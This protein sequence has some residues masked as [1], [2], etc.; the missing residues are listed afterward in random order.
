MKKLGFGLMRLPLLDADD[1]KSIDLETVK[2]MV[3]RFLERGFTYF[4]TAYAYHQGMSEITARRA[5]VERHPRDSFLLADKMP[6]FLVKGPE[7]YPRI[8]AEQLEKCGVEYFDY[9]LLHNLGAK[10]FAESARWGGFEFLMKMKREGRARHVGFSFHDTPE[11]LE[12]IL[13]EYPDMEFVQLQ[14]N[15]ADWENAT[16]QSRRCYEV[17]RAHGKPVIVME[18]VKGGSLA[19]VPE[20]AEAIF[21][22]C[23]SGHSPASWAVRYAASL[24]GVMMVLSGMSNPEQ[25]EENTGF[26]ADFQPL[27]AAEQEAVGCVAEIMNDSIAIACTGCAYCVD[28]CPKH[29]PIPKDFALFNDQSR[30][31]LMPS[32]TVYYNNLVAQGHGRAGDCIACG[33]CESHCPQHLPIIERL[34]DV[35]SVF[36]AKD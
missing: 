14:I 21:E 35:A 13:T 26:M 33:Q 30:F 28:G 10:T 31:R 19:R 3:D 29:I 16:I 1:P 27:S 36:D 32:H 5:L 22:A 8:F 2:S 18:P 6:A 23:A 20:A 17:A 7:D 25:L 15:Y 11:L 9:Y 12:R 4:D 24:E 34:R